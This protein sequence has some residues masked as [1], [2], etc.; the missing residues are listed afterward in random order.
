MLESLFLKPRRLETRASVEG[1]AA[2]RLESPER[3]KGAESFLNENTLLHYSADVRLEKGGTRP[4][5]PSF[6]IFSSKSCR[7]SFFPAVAF[8]RLPLFYLF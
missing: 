3:R 2:G 5:F 1:G 6:F 8:R 7:R 4:L